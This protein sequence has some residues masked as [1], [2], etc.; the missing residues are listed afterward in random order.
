MFSVKLLCFLVLLLS[1][2]LPAIAQKVY[3]TDSLYSL[4]FKP[5]LDKL[6]SRIL[7]DKY[8]KT[9]YTRPQ[10]EQASEVMFKLARKDGFKISFLDKELVKENL[11]KG[12]ILIIAGL[13]NDRI[14]VD[15]ETVFW[16]S[17]LSDKEVESI[18]RWVAAGGRLMLFLSH[19][20]NGSGGKPLL[21]AL[22]VRFR[23]GGASHP[24]H[25]S[26]EQDPCAW[27]TM[28]QQNKLINIAHPI[29]AQNKDSNL[30]VKTVKFLCGTAIF[31][32][33][34][35]ILLDFPNQTTH[36]SPF[37][38]EQGDVREISDEYAGML[39]FAYGK[40]K[41]IVSSDLGIF[42]NMKTIENT[43]ITY[44]TITDP[45]A[46]NAKLLIHCLRWLGK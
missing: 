22:G 20:P 37:E 4:D 46:D 10:V 24:D 9:I 33:P 34:E 26:G 21:E 6:H 32:N 36:M 11:Q 30:E 12:D 25:P 15:K 16:K 27:F 41:V 1:L 14:M 13:P 28:T 8:H 39:G 35:D 23:D 7:V 18:T 5:I 42:R 29:L 38:N 44:I 19:Y 31:R 45:A 2:H 43:I 3:V 17:P 40:G